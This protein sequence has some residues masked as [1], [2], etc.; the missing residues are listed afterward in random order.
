[1]M[2]GYLDTSSSSRTTVTVAGLLPQAYD[3]YVYVDGD[4]RIYDHGAEYTISGS[5]ISTTTVALTDPANANYSGT[6]TR[7]SNSA[8]NYVKFTINAGGFTVTA[9]PTTSGNAALRAPVN[10]IQIVPL[11]S[12]TAITR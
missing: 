6:F 1:M 9:K 5:G 8:G 10:G 11:S 12:V 3:V 7:A 4:N 2:K